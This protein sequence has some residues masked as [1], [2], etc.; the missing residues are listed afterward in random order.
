NT[1]GTGCT[2]SAAIAAGLAQGLSLEQAVTM[3]HRYLQQAIAAA[4]DLGIG[5]G[6]GPVHHF[7]AV[8]A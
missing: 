4:D 6:Q 3:A 7:H 8:W 1:H 5:R 2:L